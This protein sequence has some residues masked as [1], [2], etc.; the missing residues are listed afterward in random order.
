[1][2]EY[3]CFIDKKLYDEENYNIQRALLSIFR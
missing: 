1:M 2:R 3:G